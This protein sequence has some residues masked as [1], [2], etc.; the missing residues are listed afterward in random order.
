MKNLLE[1][2]LEMQKLPFYSEGYKIEKNRED[3]KKYTELEIE[4]QKS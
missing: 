4:I 1:Q 2:K 3:G